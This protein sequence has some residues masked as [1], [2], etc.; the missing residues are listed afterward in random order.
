MVDQ[1][2]KNVW[3]SC[4]RAGKRVGVENRCVVILML[5]EQWVDDENGAVHGN[6]SR[7]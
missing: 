3:G 4:E 7:Q 2:V 5:T 1:D 6:N